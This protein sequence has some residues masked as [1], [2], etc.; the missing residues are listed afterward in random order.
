MTYPKLHVK[1]N[2]TESSSPVPSHGGP[3]RSV[4]WTLVANGITFATVSHRF[5]WLYD[6]EHR[7]K[8]PGELEQTKSKLI[9]VWIAGRKEHQRDKRH[10]RESH[11][12]DI[13]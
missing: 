10:E 9:K 1:I 2:R 3:A 7:Y 8:T 6:G 4:T 11:D 13:R 12:N 5:Q